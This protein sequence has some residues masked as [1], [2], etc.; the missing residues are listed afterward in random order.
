MDALGTR[1]RID[2]GRATPDTSDNLN[3][4]VAAID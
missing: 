2:Q 1:I 3:S 4:E